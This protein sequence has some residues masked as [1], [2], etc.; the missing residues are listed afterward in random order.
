[1]LL[2]QRAQ[3]ISESLTLS[4][5]AKAKK[6]KAEGYD[7]I[8]FGAGEPDFSTPDF[9][10]QAAKEALDKGF[11]KYTPSSG[12]LELRQAVCRKLERDNNL[13]YTPEEIIVSNGAKHSLYNIFQAI[14][15]PGDEV[16][17]P[18]PY[19][20]SYPEMVKLADGVSVF[21]NTKEENCFKIQIEDLENAI[22]PKTKAF[23]L[24]NPCNPTGCVYEKS[25]LQEIADLAV[26]QGF[27]I[28][29]DEIYEELVYDDMQHISIASLNDRVKNLTITVNG[30]SKAYSMTG[31]RIGY[32][33]GP[34][35]IIKVMGNLQSHATSNPNSIAQYAS[36]VAL[37]APREC[38]RDMVSKFNERRTYMMERINSISNLSCYTPKGAF[39]IMMNISQAFGKKHGD[40]VIND[41]LSFSNTLLESKMVTVVPGIAFGADSF[42]RL[43][44][45]TSMDNIEKG[46]DRI[47]EFM[48][49]LV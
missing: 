41:S 14:L 2:S 28:I 11:T 42:V 35:E 38:V 27:Y 47:E 37:D 18:Q 19:W 5:D 15:N 17:I 20:L 32:A 12:T 4:I 22:T 21:V 3:S 36:T 6:M 10:I 40:S 31:W 13:I 16:I 30:M 33:A 8:G 9:I 26:E 25:E 45:A 48:E 43:S 46:L 34:R 49:E 24:N 29:S 23:I 44:Y 1:M 7:V 39:Y